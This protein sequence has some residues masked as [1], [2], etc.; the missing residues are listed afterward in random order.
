MGLS[1]DAEPR[2]DA[3][4]ASTRQELDPTG[5]HAVVDMER[6]LVEAGAGARPAGFMTPNSNACAAARI[7]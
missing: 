3:A 1:R 7:A 2:V 6:S 4:L 5:T